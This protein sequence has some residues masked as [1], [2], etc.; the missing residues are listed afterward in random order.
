[1]RA[2]F[3]RGGMASR[4]KTERPVQCPDRAQPSGYKMGLEAL[5][6]EVSNR[7]STG[8]SVVSQFEISSELV[9]Y[10]NQNADCA[11]E[12]KEASYPPDYGNG[13]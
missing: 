3:E 13:P 7:Y 2:G 10:S 12:Q 11:R 5:D 6:S 8:C 9:G 1:M 4:Q